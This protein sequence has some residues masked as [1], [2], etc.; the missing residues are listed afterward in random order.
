MMLL[1]LGRHGTRDWLKSWSMGMAMAPGSFA[2]DAPDGIATLDLD[3]TFTP[4]EDATVVLAWDFTG[5]TP[6]EAA[7]A[8]GLFDLT[9][10]V[11]VFE[12]SLSLTATAGAQ[13]F[14]VS[15]A[16]EYLWTFN[17]TITGQNEGNA[18]ASITLVPS[19][20]SGAT[21]IVGAAFALRRKRSCN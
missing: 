1:R 11:P 10:N 2:A 6:T 19:P 3:H 9:N 20:A 4:S 7:A 13:S 18:S 15:A 8:T 5:L 17:G 12:Q 21:L 16:N 14:A